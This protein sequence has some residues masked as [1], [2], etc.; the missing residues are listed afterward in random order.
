MAGGFTVKKSNI[1]IFRNFLISNFE[2]TQKKTSKLKNLYLDTIISPS[3]VNEDFFSEI[4]KLAPFG[5]GNNEPKFVIENLKV[6]K[7]DLISNKHIKSILLGK[8]GS[9]IKSVAFNAKDGPLEPFLKKNKSKNRFNAA[10]K[11][12]LNEWMGKKSVEFIIEDISL[13]LN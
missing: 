13:T 4:N 12:I 6:I 5:S 8:D 1:S 7:S 3:A 10:G 11:M 9:L 2:K